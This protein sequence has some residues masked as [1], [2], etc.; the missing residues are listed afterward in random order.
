MEN[1]IRAGNLVVG[2]IED[3]EVV[4]D[5]GEEAIDKASSR[6]EVCKYIYIYMTLKT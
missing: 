2:E 5:P 4:K 1:N 3:G 6:V